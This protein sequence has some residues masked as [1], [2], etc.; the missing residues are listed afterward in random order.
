MSWNIQVVITLGD[1]IHKT[2]WEDVFVLFQCNYVK[3]MLTIFPGA[4][5]LVFRR[6]RLSGNLWEE[7]AA[8]LKFC[9]ITLAAPAS[10]ETAFCMISTMLFLFIFSSGSCQE[11]SQQL[12]NTTGVAKLSFQNSFGITRSEKG[13]KYFI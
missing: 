5:E 10:K 6:V 8:L 12:A 3:V 2:Q 1:I 7:D 4:T 13:G 9:K 11:W